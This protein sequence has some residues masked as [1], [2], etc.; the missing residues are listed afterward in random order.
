MRLA[1]WLQDRAVGYLRSCTIVQ[2]P[3]RFLRRGGWIRDYYIPYVEGRDV[4][5]ME[6][7]G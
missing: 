6:W 7:G 1:L 5:M 2:T 4:Y 3:S